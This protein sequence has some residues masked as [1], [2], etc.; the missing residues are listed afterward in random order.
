MK[1]RRPSPR[2]YNS[3]LRKEHAQQTA[4]RILEAVLERVR[5]GDRELSYA[6]VA[7]QARV[8]L[9]TV[10]RH[11]P[12]REDLIR[13]VV[14]Q[15]EAKVPVSPSLDLASLDGAIRTFFRRFDDPDDVVRAGR[16]S[17]M[18]EISRVGTI[19]RRRAAVE[20]LVD[21]ECPGLAQPERTWLVELIVVLVSSAVGEAFR[22][23]LDRSGDETADR[24]MFAI[25]AL[26][27]HARTLAKK[28]EKKR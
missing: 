24:V 13:A 20:A 19:P 4:E 10:Y 5:L 7:K 3:D 14:A 26:I 28:K 6:A 15:Q 8:S 9:P 1:A 21:V 27:A 25:D 16:L 22:G 18:F 2:S 11:Y 23:Y 12:T 17:V